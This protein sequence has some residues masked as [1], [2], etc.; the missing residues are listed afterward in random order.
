MLTKRVKDTT[1]RDKAVIS[2]N[3]EKGVNA[4]KASACWGNPQQKEYKEK[5][6]IDSG[7]SR[8][9]TGNKCYL[10]EYEDY[11]GGFVSFG[12]E[13]QIHANVDGKAMVVSESSV[14]RDLHLNDKDGTAFLTTNEIFENLAL[15]GYEPASDKLTF[16]KV[17]VG[18]GS[19]QPPEPQPTPS[20]APPEVL[21]LITT[22]AT[23]QPPKDPSTYRR[24]KRGQNTK[25]PQSGGSPNKVD[26]EAINEE[27]LYSVERAAT[28]ATSLEAEQASG[29]G[30]WRQETMGGMQAQT[31]SEGV[32]NLSSNPPLSG[33][34]TL[35]SGENNMEHQIELMDNVPNTPHDSRLPRVNT[36]RS[37]EEILKL[38]KR[39]KELERQRKSSISHP[40]RRIYKQVESSND[41]LDEEDASKQGRTSDKTKPMF[42]DSD[43]DDLDDLVD[44]GMA[45]V[46]EKDAENQG[47]IGADD[48]EVVKGS[49][50]TEAVNTAGEGVSTAAPRTPPT[51]TTVFDDE[52]VT[53]AMAQTLIKMKEEKAKEKG[54][55]IK[56]V[57]DSSRP[58]RSITTLQ[59]LPTIDPK[60]KGKGILQETEPV[61]KTKKK[62]QGDAQIERDAEVALRLQAELDEELRVERERQ[63]EASKVAIAEMFDE[64]QARIDAD[65]ELA[66]RMTQEEQEKYTIEE[67]ARLLAEFFERRKKQLA[68]E[69]AEAI[70]NKPPTKTQL[71]NLMMTY[72]KNMGGYKHSQLKGKSYEEIQGL[73]ERQQKRI[74]DFTPMDSE[75]E[76]QK[77]GKRLKRVAGSYATQ[78]SPKKPKVMKSAKDVTEEEAA[79]YEKEKEE[80]RLSLKII[81]N[82]DSEVNYEPLSRK[83]PI[84]NW[85][86]QLLGKMEAKDMYVYKLTRA[87]GSSSYHGDTQAFLRRLDRQDLNDLYNR[88]L[89]I[90]EEALGAFGRSQTYSAEDTDT[91]QRKGHFQNLYLKLVASRGKEVN[92]EAGDSDD[93][94]VCCVENAVEDRI[95]DSGASFHATYCKK[96][97]ERF[98]LRSSKVRLADDKTLDIAGVGNVILKTSFGTSW[99]LKDVRY[100]PGLERR[101]IS[102]GQLD[103]EARGN[104][105]GSLYM[106][107]VY[108]EGI[109]V[110]INGSGSAAVWFGEAEESFFYNISEDKETAETASGFAVGI[111]Q[112]FRIVMLKMVPE[113]PL[114][115]GVAERLSQT[116][117]AEST[118]IRVEAPKMLW[119]D[120]VSTTY[121]IYRIPYVLIGLHILE[122]EWRG[123]DTSLAHLKVF[124]CDSFVKVKDVF[125]E[126][127]KCTF[128]GSGSD[129]VRYSFQDTK[130][131]QVIRSRDITFVDSIYGARS[132]TNSSSLTKPIQKSQVVL[133]DILENLADND[134][135]V[136]KHGLSSEI[137]QSPGGSSDTSEG[138]ERGS[139][140]DSGRPNEEYFED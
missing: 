140:E 75:K 23:S 93:A 95:L 16:Y 7:C 82:D 89:S 107:E 19:E 133:V 88:R 67:R 26:D 33:G 25:V 127:M 81:S 135:I 106:V 94:L 56:D 70:R 78:K 97:L 110:I 137:T 128:I 2:K 99:N 132:A 9:M 138:S 40:R 20:T 52:D 63:E 8:H 91:G 24:T 3:K 35:G 83:F 108:P 64:V 38:K 71:R 50:D 58:I 39:V 66:A 130:S 87:D 15:M 68:A 73:Y 48:T 60:D 131:H 18:E 121:L 92:M 118:G 98:K 129:E 90:S 45:F 1:A 4:V 74:Q 136:A 112:T 119:A 100:I 22:A 13:K 96:E 28:T 55:A 111:I 85:E 12:D 125:G 72:L 54:V 21:S 69:R 53:M 117:R 57:E 116:F 102:V 36:P 51:T 103:E 61:E 114:Q 31:R 34:H 49:G 46:Q 43:F 17:V 59:P 77:P 41:D 37:D 123:K 14:R 105:R 6:V 139:F 11:D 76:A 79:E 115:F 126:A 84:M 101:L 86:Y 109:G 27:M 124:G 5:G 65:Y 42:K 47:K 80:L 134:S 29:S 104:K 44:E 62:V 120:S 122:E 10:I 113:T 30:P 32:S